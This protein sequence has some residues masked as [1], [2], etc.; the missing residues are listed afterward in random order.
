MPL[1][2]SQ[3]SLDA[4]MR[5]LNALLAVIDKAIAHAEAKKFDPNLYCAMRLR[6]DMFTF[7][8]QVQTACDQAKNAASRLAAIEPPR[9]EDNETTIAELKARIQ[10]TLAY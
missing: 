5:A 8:R 4:Y 1:S 2:L 7:A 6:P 9:F 3:C 10:K